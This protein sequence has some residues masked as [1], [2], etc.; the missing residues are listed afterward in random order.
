MR[1]DTRRIPHLTVQDKARARNAVR[2]GAELGARPLFD[3]SQQGGAIPAPLRAGAISRFFFSPR[4]PR[5]PKE[6]RKFLRGR[7]DACFLRNADISGC[8]AGRGEFDMSNLVSNG[9][10]NANALKQKAHS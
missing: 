3:R 9:M 5:T 7:T 2:P 1:S 4:A 10:S 8:A 6:N